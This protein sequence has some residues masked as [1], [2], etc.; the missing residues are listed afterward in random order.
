MKIQPRCELHLQ[1]LEG[2]PF[3]VDSEGSRD[4]ENGPFE[5]DL[6][7]MYCPMLTEE[8]QCQTVWSFGV[9]V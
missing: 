2:A 6:S 3:I 1:D 5:L 7:D 8:A 9:G 4:G